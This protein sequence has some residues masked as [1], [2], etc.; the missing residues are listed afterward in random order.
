MNSQPEKSS[1]CADAL[2][3]YRDELFFCSFNCFAS[4]QADD[5]SGCEFIRLNRAQLRLQRVTK[6]NN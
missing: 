1:A 3:F 6:K 5:F 2:R 4:A